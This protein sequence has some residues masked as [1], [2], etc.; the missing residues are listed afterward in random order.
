MSKQMLVL[1]L[2]CPHCKELLTEGNR[3]HLDAYVKDS[4][5]DG[6]VF[7]SAVF[8]EYSVEGTIDIPEGAMAEFRCPKCDQSIMIALYC[9]TCNAP[10]ASLNQSGGGYIEFCTRRG[11]KGHAIGGAGDIDEM[12]SLMNKKFNTPYD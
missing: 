6:E 2:C 10:M 4:N 8:G 1:Q 5:R 9:R 11:C 12:I 7:L 3:I